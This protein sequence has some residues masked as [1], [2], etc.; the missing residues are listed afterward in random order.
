MRALAIPD[1]ARVTSCQRGCFLSI[2]VFVPIPH[3]CTTRR[4]HLRP[5]A[6]EDHRDPGA[7]STS[8]SQHSLARRRGE[9]ILEAHRCVRKAMRIT[10]VAQRIEP[11]LPVDVLGVYVYLPLG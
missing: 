7:V 3:S 6:V 4:C 9:E 1:A 11:K 5:P 10:G 2:L 8:A